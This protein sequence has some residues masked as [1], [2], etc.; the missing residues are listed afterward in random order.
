M[1][2]EGLCGRRSLSTSGSPSCGRAR[3][4]RALQ[5]R[6]PAYAWSA[7][8]AVVGGRR[9]WVPRQVITQAGKLDDGQE[10]RV[11]THRLR[12]TCGVSEPGIAPSWYAAP[13]CRVVDGQVERHPPSS[14]VELQLDRTGHQPETP[15]PVGQPA[16]TAAGPED[17]ALPGTHHPGPVTG[18]DAPGRNSRVP[19]EA[20]GQI[21][22]VGVSLEQPRTEV[23]CGHPNCWRVRSEPGHNEKHYAGDSDVVL[24]R[25]GGGGNRTRVLGRRTGSTGAAG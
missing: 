2:I 25:G 21:H 1:L 3:P 16:A 13:L 19:A 4:A 18:L 7:A 23:G 11:R 24:L 12:N 20:F 9:C 15:D 8:A 10:R 22:P 14:V 6:V 17:D 5:H